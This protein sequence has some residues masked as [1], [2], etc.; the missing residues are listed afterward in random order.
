M[1][2]FRQIYRTVCKFLSMRVVVLVVAA[3][4]IGRTGF[5]ADLTIALDSETIV[6]PAMV[7]LTASA[8]VEQE[9]LSYR[10]IGLPNAPRCQEA[11]CT[12]DIAVSSC[13]SIAVEAVN[14]LGE[15]LKATRSLCA[16]DGEG[17]L[18]PHFELTIESG[19]MRAALSGGNDP[20]AVQRAWVDGVEDLDDPSELTFEPSGGCHALDV[21]AADTAGRIAIAQRTICFDDDPPELWVG[22]KPSA[23][24]AVGDQFQPCVEKASPLGLPLMRTAGELELG[25]CSAERDAPRSIEHAFI[26]A[27]DTR[28]IESTASAFFAAT[29]ASGKPVLFFAD[30]QAEVPAKQFEELRFPVEVYGGSGPFTVSGLSGLVVAEDLGD[31][32]TLQLDRVPFAVGSMAVSLTLRD[33]RGLEAS[34]HTTLNVSGKPIVNDPGNNALQSTGAACRCVNIERS[35]AWTF[36][37]LFAGLALALRRRK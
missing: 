15:T 37:L 19:R 20:V 28:G 6:A 32:V 25:G 17:G 26:S 36:A 1:I 29:P 33:G 5:A 16:S 27:K 31:R 18:P 14:T 21:F 30:A 23:F 4:A 35:S 24:A 3:C 12:I 8:A 10:W 34:V 22:G 11:Q 9:I 7:T 13:T 2:A